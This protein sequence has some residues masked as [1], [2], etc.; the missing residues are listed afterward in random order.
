MVLPSAEHTGQLFMSQ[1]RM[2]NRK[3]GS[4]FSKS[5]LGLPKRRHG[6]LGDSLL[7]PI[8]CR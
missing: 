2:E 8:Q 1:I 3:T 7:G 4:Q 6:Y 5:A